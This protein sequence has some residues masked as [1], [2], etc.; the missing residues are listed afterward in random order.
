MKTLVVDNLNYTYPNG[1][2]ALRGIDLFVGEGEKV[3]LTGPN[4]SG[5]STL[6][7]CLAGLL[8]T[9]GLEGTVNWT[10]AEPEKGFLFQ[11]PDDQIIGGTVKDDV[12]FVLL[13]KGL[14]KEEAAARVRDALEKVRL[15]DC[16]ERFPLEMSFGE[17]K[18]ICLAG[19]LAGAPDFL[20][21]DEP[22][23]GLDPRQTS[24]LM[25]ILGDFDKS[26][27]VAS[28]NFPLISRLA[29]RVIV[30]D[31][32]RIRGAG[33]PGEILADRGLMEACG[34]ALEGAGDYRG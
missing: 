28:M 2:R 3:A 9:A 30:I 7:L 17:K 31:R 12:G 33:P 34:L 22:A 10:G 14:G 23:L 20:F 27:L 29:D 21:L 6:L 25:D 16:G 4:G 1:V 24:Q 19:L 15:K 26:M 5:K 8:G 32:G 11:N 18:R 13:K